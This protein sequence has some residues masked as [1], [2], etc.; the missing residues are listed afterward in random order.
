VAAEQLVGWVE[1]Q[2]SSAGGA[3]EEL[4]EAALVLAG[5][6]CKVSLLSLCAFAQLKRNSV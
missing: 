4:R 1:Q 3:S 5:A 6:S 2:L